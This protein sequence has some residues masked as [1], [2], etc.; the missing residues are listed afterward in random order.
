MYNFKA[1]IVVSMATIFLGA[2]PLAPISP[3]AKPLRIGVKGELGSLHPIER[4]GNGPDYVLYLL[5]QPLVALGK[6]WKWECR[7]CEDLPTEENG[8]LRWFTNPKGRSY[9]R[10]TFA[11]KPNLVWNDGSPLTSRDIKFSW[12]V[13]KKM[14]LEPYTLIDGVLTDPKDPRFFSLHITNPTF[15]YEPLGSF[16][17]I[18]SKLELPI[19]THAQNDVAMYM[20]ASLY[21]TQP[22]T[23]GLY[24]GAFQVD[25]T[26]D[27]DLA[28]RP[29]PK[30]DAK[31]RN[32][33]QI[34]FFPQEKALVDALND[35]KIDMTEESPFYS[36]VK[37]D[38]TRIETPGDSLIFEEIICNLRNPILRERNVREALFH[39][40]DRDAILQTIYKGRGTPAF[41][42]FHP[43]DPDFNAEITIHTYDLKKAGELLD[44]VGWR[45][46]DGLRRKGPNVL[47]LNLVTF[48]EPQRHATAEY[49][50]KAWALIGVELQINFLQSFS[51]YVEEVSKIR[52]D[53]L[54]LADIKLKAGVPVSALFS[55]SEIPV[56]NN[57]YTGQNYSYWSNRKVDEVVAALNRN[58]S[59]IKRRELLK[60]LQREY[61]KNVPTIPLLFRTQA[62]YTPPNLRGFVVSG[63]QFPSSLNAEH[64]RFE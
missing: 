52:F 44:A 30:M 16:H 23:P 57:D 4:L 22:N 47:R 46:V 3:A 38:A 14:G 55:S 31:S 34:K 32:D 20:T 41:T 49:L 50:K 12:Q 61:A 33:V 7:L 45:M 29:N 28:L 54:A 13:G 35:G 25:T 9:L 59:L 6:D 64:W 60:V 42:P 8:R 56:T 1:L 10:V 5:S 18:S 39:A 48:D 40:T 17:V 58:N 11:L 2:T 21:V 24:N 36:D 62:A 15:I 27:K 63:H 37:T 26:V 53:G 19:W 43:N 51:S